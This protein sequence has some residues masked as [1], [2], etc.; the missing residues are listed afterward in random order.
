MSNINLMCHTPTWQGKTAQMNN[1]ERSL[2]EAHELF[3]SNSRGS[4]HEDRRLQ[5]DELDEWRTHKLRTHVKQKLC[6]NELN[7]FPHQLKVGDKVLLDAANPHI[8]T[9][10]PNEEIPLTVLSIFPFSTVVVSHPKFGTFKAWE[11]RTKP[12]TIVRH[13]RV[14]PHSQG[15]RAWTNCSKAPKFK[16]CESHGKKLGNTGVLIGRMSQN[17]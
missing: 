4:V 1:L 3:S 6:Q 8:V 15:T 17:L 5:F 16:I 14:H 11:K 13:G 12:G 10:I 7:T 9:T 2:K